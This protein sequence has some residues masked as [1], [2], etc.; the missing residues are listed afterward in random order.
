[1]KFSAVKVAFLLIFLSCCLVFKPL[2]AQQFSQWE[3]EIAAFELADR[4]HQTPAQSIVFTG[5][6]SIRL[7]EGLNQDFPDKKILNR[8]FGGSQTDAVVFFAN[9]IVVPYKPRQV[10]IY[11]GDNDLAAGKSPE[12]VLADFKDLF[13][14]IRR[15]VPNATI[16]FISIKP[17]P[18]RK[19]I[20]EK[21]R[22]TNTLVKGFLSSQQKTGY[23]DVFT[24]MLLANGKPRPELFLADSLHMTR[25]G[26]VIWAAA[27]RP[28][29]K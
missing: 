5:S 12:K 3:K 25:A 1:M 4:A 29:L 11:S 23:V 28:Y 7:W 2:Q 15:Q 20:L 8:G 16:T 19:H 10:V 21:V 6:S 14:R 24:P 17:S 22:H 27:L 18:S 26:Y 13:F 9:R